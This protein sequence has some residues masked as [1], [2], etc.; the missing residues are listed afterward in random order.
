LSAWV[1]GGA[2]LVA[3]IDSPMRA[4]ASPD[5]VVNSS[6]RGDLALPAEAKELLIGQ[7]SVLPFSVELSPNVV[8]SMSYSDSGIY[9]FVGSVV[10]D[11][12]SEVRVSLKHIN[13][14]D[15]RPIQVLR[16]EQN[17]ITVAINGTSYHLGDPWAFGEDGR[18]LSTRFDIERSQL[19]QV[20]EADG[21]R[22]KIFFD[23]TYTPNLCSLGYYAE[24]YGATAFLDMYGPSVDYGL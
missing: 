10:S 16:N 18:K 14:C 6:T 17:Q 19:V 15:L 13:P 3:P 11:G 1:L 23:P 20:I 2:I 24:T 12:F 21:Y 7:P 5:C 9:Q 4:S 22:G 8:D